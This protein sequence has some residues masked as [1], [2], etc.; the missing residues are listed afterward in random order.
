MI[1]MASVSMSRPAVQASAAPMQGRRRGRWLGLRRVPGRLALVVFRMP[2][3]LY[4][5]GWGWLLGRRFLALTH[6]GRTTGK[7][8]DTVAMVLADDHDSGEVVI[9]SAWGPGADW[10][11]NLRAAPAPEVRVGRDRYFPAHRFLAEDEAVVVGVAFRHE[12]PRRL[13]LLSALLG[14]GDLTRDAA[15]RD[16]V[17]SHPFVALWPADKANIEER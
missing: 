2:L 7:P 9:C 17:R 15:L 6:V 13:R 16:F 1:V 5:R 12:H 4:R 3:R 8:Y 11:R 10:V 14:W